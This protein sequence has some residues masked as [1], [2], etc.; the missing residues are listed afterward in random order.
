MPKSRKSRRKREWTVLQK[1]H[2]MRTS[3]FTLQRVLVVSVLSIPSLLLGQWTTIPPDPR[4]VTGGTVNVGT[5]VGAN[6]SL[7]QVRGLDVGMTI[8]TTTFTAFGL[9]A[10]STFRTVTPSGTQNYWSM[11]KGASTEVGQLFSTGTTS[12]QNVHFNV[13]ATRG[14]LRLWSTS[15][16]EALSTAPNT[17]AL[18]RLQLNRTQTSNI[19]GFAGINT[20][21]FVAISERPGFFDLAGIN[22]AFSRLHLV[23][24]IGSGTPLVY[25]QQF[26]YRP[27][28]RNGI[29]FTGNSDQSYI[30]QQYNGND[31]TDFV[32]QWSDN[33]QSDPWGCDRMRFVFNS[34]YNG[35]HTSGMNSLQGMEAMRMWPK[36]GTEVNV[37]I[38]DFGV[39]GSGD[40]T[41]RL[42]LLTG[43]LRIRALPTEAASN[44][45]DKLMVVDT[46]GVVHWR[47]AASITAA[48][49]KWSL[50]I[51]Q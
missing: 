14:H 21:G 31:K 38:G 15:G 37:G 33:P 8:P 5:A 45:L 25:A 24:D 35:G 9:G 3:L 1:H 7:L 10:Q 42:D 27:W 48:D 17:S 26:G 49:C 18:L 51:R 11:F 44:A 4:L 32:I 40:P 12:F 23:D 46:T 41:Q 6:Q 43:S 16:T 29:T 19:N 47:D 34:A 28:Q 13:G 22:G 2:A 36:S 30:G 39:P 20:S 50:L